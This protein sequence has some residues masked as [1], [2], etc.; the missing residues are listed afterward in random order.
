MSEMISV[1][2]TCGE[3]NSQLSKL[4]SQ[5]MALLS[6]IGRLEAELTKQRGDSPKAVMVKRLHK[7]WCETLLLDGKPR[8]AKL[9]PA[10]EKAYLFALTNY[11]E[12]F[13]HQA[14]DGCALK[15][16]VGPRGRQATVEGGAKRFDDPTLIFRDETTIERFAGYVD[17]AAEAET[18][19]AAK[20]ENDTE[21]HR[22][23]A[24][25]SHDLAQGKHGQRIAYPLGLRTVLEQLAERNLTVRGSGSSYK[26]Q[27]PAHE[28]REPS[29]QITEKPDGMVLLHCFA[30]C[31]T[32]DV[33]ADLGL[34]FGDIGSY[35]PS[36]E[37]VAGRGSQLNLG[38][39]A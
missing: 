9:G 30:G 34:G 14:I 28:D 23:G 13:C 39:A 20:T 27:C 11:E 29:L 2:P 26:A 10:R 17:E 37:F 38:E 8:K 24:W 15:P 31:G 25:I 5:N 18:A 36:S 32:S 35:G 22:T 1:C 19:T 16:F 4:Q 7:H 6:K 12:E 33:L 3:V 21:S